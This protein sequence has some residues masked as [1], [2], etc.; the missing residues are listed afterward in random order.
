VNLQKIVAELRAE[1]DRLDKAIAAL[2]GVSTQPR[3]GRPPKAVQTSVRPKRRRRMSAAG[4]ARIAA[5]QRARWAKV[6]QSQASKPVRRMSAAARR[7]MSRLMKQRWAQ[8]K[9]KRKKTA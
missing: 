2:N 5:A 4:R 3:R 9:M 8:G 7:K 6:K 1:R